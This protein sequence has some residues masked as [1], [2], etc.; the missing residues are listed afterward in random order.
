MSHSNLTP[1]IQP[2]SQSEKEPKDRQRLNLQWINQPPI[3]LLQESEI[4]VR[5]QILKNNMK[6]WDPVAVPDNPGLDDIDQRD[7]K[8]PKRSQQE[9]WNDRIDATNRMLDFDFE[10]HHVVEYRFASGPIGIMA[11]ID[12]D[13]VSIADIVTH[14]GSDQAGGILIE[15]AVQKSEE[16]G[17]H[18]RLKLYALTDDAQK[19]Y[20]Q[21]GFVVT[22]GSNMTLDPKLCANIWTMVGGVQWRLT[23]YQNTT[24]YLTSATKS[25]P[26]LP[27]KK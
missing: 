12:V 20:E 23:K 1:L 15:Y 24:S 27:N 6:G 14:P 5:L 4:P 18:G 25:L 9:R 2:G 19:A 17:K 3:V 11:L 16:W 13:P 10:T 7:W 21:L 22:T 8:N 26:I